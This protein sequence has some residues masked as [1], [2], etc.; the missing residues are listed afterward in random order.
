MRL[1]PEEHYLAHLL[2]VKIHPEHVGLKYAA[3]M[4]GNL[5][6]NKE[7]GWVKRKHAQMLSET[8]SGSLHPMYGKI[9][10]MMGRKHTT[11]TKR[12]M[13]ESWSMD[14][15]DMSKPTGKDSPNYGRKHRA[16]SIEKMKVP[17]PEGF[18][19]GDRNSM[20]GKSH[21]E[22][23]R[24]LMSDRAKN[25]PTVQCPHCS[26]SGAMSQMKRWHFDNCRN[27]SDI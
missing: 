14:N 4:M 17:K 27:R 2:L 18:A 12:K 1:L 15:R 5:G 9:G 11:E 10:T 25:R 16:E 8:R 13:S 22:S 24:Q 21:K 19:L 3:H 26:V 6:N 7:H 23:S 20:F